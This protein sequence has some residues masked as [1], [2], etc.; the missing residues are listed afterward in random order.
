MKKSVVI[1]A[2]RIPSINNFRIDYKSLL[3]FI[4]FVCGLIL[5]ITII[6]KSNSE[7][8]DLIFKLIKNNLTAINNSNFINV[9]SGTF[10]SLVLLLFYIYIF[11]QCSV[12]VPFIGLTPLFWGVYTG[13]IVSSLYSIYGL[14]GIGFCSIVNLPCYAITAATLVRGCCIGV[15]YSNEIFLAILS[16]EWKKQSDYTIKN[17]TLSFVVLIIPLIISAVLKAGCSKLFSE[18]FVLF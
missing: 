13:V 6:E 3:F 17:Y 1:K 4:I 11:G 8:I 15:N 9:F 18:L 7:I 16:G 2:K 10:F 5:G 14:K 12:G